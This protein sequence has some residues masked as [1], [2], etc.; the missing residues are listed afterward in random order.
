MRRLRDGCG[1]YE[2]NCFGVFVSNIELKGLKGL[3]VLEDIANES[4]HSQSTVE[5]LQQLPVNFLIPG[6]Y[7]P[8]KHITDQA[9]NELADSIKTQ[10][11][12]QPLIA[13]K[14]NHSQ[15]E[16][17][18][19]E[20]RWRAAGMAGLTYVPVIIREIADNVAL[21]F[22]LIENI[23][24]ENLNP[25]EEAEAFSRF[26]EEFSMTHA[27]IAN[28]IG[29]SRAAVTNTMRLLSLT[30]PVRKLLTEGELDMGHARAILSIEPEQQWALAEKIIAKQLTV[31]E[32]EKLANAI[33]F[34]KTHKTTKLITYEDK[35]HDWSVMLSEKLAAK[36]SVK[37]N[38]QGSGKIIIHVDSPD[39]IDRLIKRIRID[40]KI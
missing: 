14:I 15:Y 3:R 30:D 10:G 23:Q 11:I 33:K 36:V 17:I 13:R 25:I 9:L 22:A 18:A 16:I 28:M 38:D 20:R 24:R 4:K 8:R 34:P 40:K 21:A 1:V 2:I 5:T 32:A 26:K 35:Y 39:E 29:R 27:E 37:L 7:Q 12:I 19:G 31:R 6:K